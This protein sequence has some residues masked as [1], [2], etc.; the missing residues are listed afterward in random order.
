MT[1]RRQQLLRLAWAWG[2]VL[3]FMALIFFF[4]AQPKN[5]PPPDYS[6]DVYMSGYSPV[7]NGGW[8]VLIKK[9]SHVMGY[10]LFALVVVRALSAHPLPHREQLLLAIVL[11]MT[12]AIT[13]EL[14]QSLVPGRNATV[15]DIGLDFAGACFACLLLAALRGLRQ[16]ML[17]GAPV[18]HGFR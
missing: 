3:V 14:H 8:E 18:S 10:G 6:G 2:P 17:S 4:S 13:D 16:T 12:Y 15:L 9:G 11:V 1:Q 7:F 5:P